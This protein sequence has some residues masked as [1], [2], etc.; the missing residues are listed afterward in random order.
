M[1]EFEKLAAAALQGDLFQPGKAAVPDATVPDVPP[2]ADNREPMPD[3]EDRATIE[4]GEPQAAEVT[5]ADS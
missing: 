5:G 1:E 4:L 3:A 2:E